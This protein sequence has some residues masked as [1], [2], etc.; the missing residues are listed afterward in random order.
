VNMKDPS[1]TLNC[2]YVSTQ[3]WKS[4]KDWCG[5]AKL[6]GIFVPDSVLKVSFKTACYNHDK[7]YETCGKTRKK[8]DEGLRDDIKSAC[9]VY[10]LSA[11]DN[12][13]SKYPWYKPVRRKACITIEA[14]RYDACTLVAA[15]YYNGVRLGAQIPY[16]DAQNYDNSNP[17]CV[18]FNPPWAESFIVACPGFN[19]D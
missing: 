6:K 18:K 13:K 16:V 9:S 12:C 10:Y 15:A 1:G 19:V 14:A 3:V 11:V 17:H 2:A 5:S 8:C 7:C 4:N